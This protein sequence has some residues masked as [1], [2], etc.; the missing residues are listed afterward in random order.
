MQKKGIIESADYPKQSDTFSQSEVRLSK[1]HSGFIQLTLVIMS[2][3]VY[4]VTLMLFKVMITL[5]LF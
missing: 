4:P 2:D 5:C 3:K 1:C